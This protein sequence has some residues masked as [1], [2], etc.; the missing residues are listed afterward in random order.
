M[1]NQ[2]QEPR[3]PVDDELA[4]RI[5]AF[6]RAGRQR[7]GMGD[8]TPVMG[9]DASDSLVP[10]TWTFADADAAVEQILAG[11]KTATSAVLSD[12]TELGSE[13]V[14]ARGD[15]AIV[16]DSRAEPRAL[17]RAEQVRTVR[18]DEVDEA[19]A[20]AELAMEPSSAALAAWHEHN[21]AGADDPAAQ[22]LLERFTLVHPSP[23]A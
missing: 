13:G 20:G 8:L 22:V 6:W 2:V 9:E 12:L 4:A 17:V 1:S 10:P 23:T 5:V 19:H 18:V 3:D 7:L 11:R 21:D 15:V 16:L 14:P